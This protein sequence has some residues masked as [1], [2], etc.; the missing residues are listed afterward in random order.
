MSNSTPHTIRLQDGGLCNF[1]RRLGNGTVSLRSLLEHIP[2]PRHESGRRHSLVLILLIVFVALLRGS[3][4]L[5]DAH[6]F[7]SLNQPFFGMQLEIALPHGIPDPTTISRVLGRLEPEELIRAYLT[8]LQ[9]LGVAQGNVLSY[10]GKTMRAVSGAGAIRHI[11]SFFS[12]RHSPG[13]WPSRGAWQRPG[14]S[15][16]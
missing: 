7:A 1:N 16:L 14:D 13:A 5:K 15:G 11:L 4:D 10:D 8:F 12:Q 3:K 2:D 9:M 6:L